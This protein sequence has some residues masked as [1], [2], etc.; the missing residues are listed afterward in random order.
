VKVSIVTISFNS[1]STIADTIQ[2]VLGQKYSEVEY[3]I[4]D[5]GSTDETLAIAGTFGDRLTVIQQPDKGIY[6]AMNQGVA[7]ATGDVIG[8]L[9]SD[10]VYADSDVLTDV[11]KL[12]EDEK[13]DVVYADLTYV[14]RDDLGVVTR[15]WRSG[16][17]KPGDFRKGWMPP[18]PTFFIRA[19]YYTE[20]GL[21]NTELRTSAD[22]ELMLRMMHIHQLRA[23][24]LS[25]VIVKM[26][27]GGQSNVSLKNRLKANGEDRKAWKL[28][29]MNPPFMLMFRKP[30][31]KL[32]QFF[33]KN[34]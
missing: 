15:Y 1:A 22:Y 8:I 7:A 27:D 3:I 34:V 17:Y 5:G 13:I 23:V 6:H 18:H 28:N 20:F 30:L 9:N 19:R 2:S 11:M 16:T 25:R 33:R 4:K 10:D 29:G 32:G 31:R 12:F 26:R 24:Y 14:K 21:Y